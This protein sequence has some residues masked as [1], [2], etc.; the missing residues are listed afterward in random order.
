MTQTEIRVMCLQGKECQGLPATTRSWEKD[1][2]QIIPQTLQKELS[3][4]TP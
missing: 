3:L 2:E 4:L 1:M